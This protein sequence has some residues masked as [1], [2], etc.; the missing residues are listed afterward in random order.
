MS[1]AAEQPSRIRIVIADD[2]A[3]VRA[4][5]RSVLSRQADMA[6]VGEASSAAE[7]QRRVTELAPD[8]V[9]TDL[10]MPGGGVLDTVR[11]VSGEDAAAPRARVVVF[12]AFDDASDAVL[13]LRAGALGYVLKQSL[14]GDILLAVRRARLGRRY[15]DAQLAARMVEEGLNADGDGPVVRLAHLSEREASVLELV[16]RGYTGPEIAVELG[17]RLGTVETFRHRIRKKLGLKSRAE[18]TQFARSAAFRRERP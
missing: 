8:V 16:A 9:I 5:L 11:A 10:R 4:G 1:S 15:V 7:L 14:E 3:V 17:V 13:A 12:S 2:H 6:V 18:V